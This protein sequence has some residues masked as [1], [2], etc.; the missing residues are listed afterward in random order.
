VATKYAAQF[1]RIKL[2]TLAQVFGDWGRVQ[3]LWFDDGGIFDQIY[4]N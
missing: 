2:F 3:K 4:Q 1:P